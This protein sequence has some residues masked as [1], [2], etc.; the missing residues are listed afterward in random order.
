MKVYTRLKIPNKKTNVLHNIYYATLNIIRKPLPGT[1][2]ADHPHLALPVEIDTPP[3]VF[4]DIFY[5]IL[6]IIW[7]LISIKNVDMLIILHSMIFVWIDLM[8][9]VK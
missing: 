4:K 9:N 8:L 2:N 6:L 5:K 1:A 3:I 7:M